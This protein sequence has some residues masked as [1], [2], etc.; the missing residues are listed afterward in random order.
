MEVQEKI[1]E[2]RGGVDDTAPQGLYPPGR[3]IHFIKT[4]EISKSMRFLRKIVPFCSTYSRVYVGVEAENDSFREIV[5][6]GS[7]AIDHFPDRV[8]ESIEVS[9]RVSQLLPK[10][11]CSDK[12]CCMDFFFLQNMVDEWGCK[13]LYKDCRSSSSSIDIV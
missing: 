3:I 12:I 6:S 2:K 11:K 9:D 13:D 4:D 7:M 8:C 5:L 10:K 1:K